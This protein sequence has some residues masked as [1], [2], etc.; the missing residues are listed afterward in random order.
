MNW[1]LVLQIIILCIVLLG[2]AVVGWA[3]WDTTQKN[4]HE[5]N[6]ETLRVSRG[7]GRGE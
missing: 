1:E 2:V 3:M 5:R 7:G 4:K 6:L